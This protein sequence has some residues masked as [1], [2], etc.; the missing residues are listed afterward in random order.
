MEPMKPMTPMQFDDPVGDILDSLPLGSSD[1][2]W[3]SAISQRQQDN[4]HLRVEVNQS[5]IQGA[6]TPAEL[7]QQLQQA[8]AGAGV[9]S[10]ELV[11]Q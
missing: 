1:K 3:G 4:G 9:Q 10:V 5:A 6:G 2:T 7:K 11:V 8:L